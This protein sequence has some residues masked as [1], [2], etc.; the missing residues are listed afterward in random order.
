[1]DAALLLVS[2]QMTPLVEVS[3]VALLERLEQD[4]QSGKSIEMKK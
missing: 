2:V 3:C 1:M 4:A